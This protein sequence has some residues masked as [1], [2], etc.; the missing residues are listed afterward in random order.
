MCTR[1]QARELYTESNWWALFASPQPAAIH[2]Y[3]PV[4]QSRML[5]VVSLVKQTRETYIV[6]SYMLI[7]QWILFGVVVT[8][9]VHAIDVGGRCSQYSVQSSM[10]TYQM[11]NA[12]TINGIN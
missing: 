1:T 3:L 9:D 7:A 5:M 4:K 10:Y 12:N 6:R 11:V 8:T 2:T